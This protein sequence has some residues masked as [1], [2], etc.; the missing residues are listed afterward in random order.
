ML[1]PVMM[2]PLAVCSAAPTRKPEY[3]AIARS[4]ASRAAATRRVTSASETLKDAL[5]QRDELVADAAGGL[6]HFF[7]GERLRQDACRHVRD[8]GNAQHL[9]AHVAGRD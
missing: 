8:T 7:F 4:R 2:S 5:Q 9:D 3:G 6:D 1:Q